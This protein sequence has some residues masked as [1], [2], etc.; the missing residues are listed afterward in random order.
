M[1][2]ALS[3]TMPSRRPATTL[4]VLSAYLLAV[5][6]GGWFHT[7]GRCG[8]GSAAPACSSTL[9]AFSPDG[10]GC[11]YS[12]HRAT[13]SSKTPD[14]RGSSGG[15]DPDTCP[16]CHFLAHKPIPAQAVVVATSA[17]RFA[18]VAPAAP[19]PVFA[20][21]PSVHHSRAPPRAA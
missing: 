9:G 13:D 17:A 15:H 8:D 1:A 11:P 14:Q 2:G 7:H 4:F 5:T 16:V 12:H 6:V 20:D 19:A 10:G 3:G 21:V 18:E